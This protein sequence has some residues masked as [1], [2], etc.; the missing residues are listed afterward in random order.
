MIVLAA[1]EPMSDS[2][3]RQR[4]ASTLLKLA[5]VVE[6]PAGL[7]GIAEIDGGRG[8]EQQRVGA[9]AAVDR[10]FGAVIGHGVV[11]DAGGDRSAPPPPSIVS[12][13][14]PVVMVLAAEEPVID[15]AARQ[16]RR[17]R[18]SGNC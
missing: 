9:G 10:D 7:V 16:R 5:T 11:A 15:S 1:D 17:V 14:E 18:R 2:A 3:G 8:A 6:S 13:P 4:E 12:L